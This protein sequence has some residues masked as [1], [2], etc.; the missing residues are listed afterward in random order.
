MKA[1]VLAKIVVQSFHSRQILINT[2]TFKFLLYHR[3]EG[4]KLC[5]LPCHEKRGAK[6][7]VSLFLLIFCQNSESNTSDSPS[8]PK[9]TS[10]L[11]LQSRRIIALGT[12]LVNLF[13]T[14]NLAR[15][16]ILCLIEKWRHASVTGC[17]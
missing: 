12:L 10:R 17:N 9:E 1:E 8:I 7:K 16:L 13:S 3:A 11:A 5:R 14:C 15:Y 2:C 6:K 4:V